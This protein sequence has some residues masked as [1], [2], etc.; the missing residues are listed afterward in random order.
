MRVSAHLVDTKMNG[1][2]MARRPTVAGERLSQVAGWPARG[3]LGEARSAQA[4]QASLEQSGVAL[5][6]L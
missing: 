1:A 4:K 5:K 6:R 3:P 2:P